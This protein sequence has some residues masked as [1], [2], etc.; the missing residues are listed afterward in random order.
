MS[1]ENKIKKAIRRRNEVIDLLKKGFLEPVDDEDNSWRVK[2]NLLVL[3]MQ[4][5]SLLLYYF[6]DF[7]DNE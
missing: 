5:E 7:K 1:K 2:H 3:E 4:M 6:K